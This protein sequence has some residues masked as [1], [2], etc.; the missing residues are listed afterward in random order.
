MKIIHIVRSLIKTSGVSVFVAELANAQ[1]QEGHEVYLYYTWDPEYPLGANVRARCLQNLDEIKENPDVVHIHGLW[2]FDMIRAMI[3]CRKSGKRY[4][5]SPHGGLMPRVLNKGWLKKHIFYWFF[6]KRN[7]QCAAAIHCTGESERNAVEALGLKPPKIIVPLGCKIPPS[8]ER[9]GD[10]N[11][12]NVLF[13][14]RL[15]EEKGLLYLLDAWKSVDH[16]GWKLTIA[17]PSWLGYGEK[18]KSKVED[19]GIEG[20]EFTGSADEKMKDTLYRASDLF[21]LPSPMENF[22]MVVLDALAYGVPVICTKGT[23]WKCIEENRCGWWIESNSVAVIC[24]ALEEAMNLSRSEMQA[25]GGRARKLAAQFSWPEV[26]K[27]LELGM[28]TA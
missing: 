28:R 8:V 5:V 4:V 26:A 23:P 6:L 7:L 15:G 18:L 16:R 12:R 25:M 2:S 11:Q 17:G 14:G 9:M 19:E 24:T 10:G 1:A 13:L 3:W 21:I 20:V 22:S 27:K